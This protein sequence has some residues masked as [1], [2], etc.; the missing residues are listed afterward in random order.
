MNIHFR[1]Y[2]AIFEPFLQIARR[3]NIRRNMFFQKFGYS[4]NIKQS[5]WT[6]NFF[7]QFSNTLKHREMSFNLRIGSLKLS[8]RQTVMNKNLPGSLTV[9]SAIMDTATGIY[10][11]PA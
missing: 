2:R 10:N 8:R 1:Q 3:T 5:I 4:F 7:F 6:P 11:Q 9:D